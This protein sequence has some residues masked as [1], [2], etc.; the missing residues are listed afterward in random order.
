MSLLSVEGTTVTSGFELLQKIEQWSSNNIE[1][2][3]L[4]CTMDV[5]DLYTMIPQVSGA[6]SLRK[7]LDYL[8]IKQIDGLK[9]EV[10]IRLARFV[11]TNSGA[12]GCPLT[13]IIANC[14]MFFFEQNIVKQINNSF[15]L[16]VRFIDDIFIAIDWPKQRFLKQI[17]RWNALDSNKIKMVRYLLFVYHKP[18]Y[19]P[20]YL[21]FNSIHPLHMKKNIPFAMLLRAIRYCSTFKE[22]KKERDQMK[23]ALLLKQYPSQLIDQQLNHVFYE[24][25]IKLQMNIIHYHNIRQKIINSPLQVKE[26]IDYGHKMFIHFT[27]C[28]NIRNFP[29]KFH[30]L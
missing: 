23:M 24:Y 25:D 16:Y 22:Y 13:L 3:T 1:Q 2:E 19:Q 28:S 30:N 26:P 14:Y 29:K 11:M 6:L 5:T 7:M 8:N 12:M 10:I 27:Y 17:D 9:T 20:Y 21:P 4:L 15:G 18:S